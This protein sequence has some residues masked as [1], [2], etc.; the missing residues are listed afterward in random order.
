[1]ADERDYDVRAEILRVM[2]RKL[3]EETYPSTSMLDLIE[4]LL[5]PEDL[6]AYAEALVNRIEADRY[7]SMPIVARLKRLGVPG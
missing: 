7:P 1:M 4:Q 6:P 3:E 2:M 5:T